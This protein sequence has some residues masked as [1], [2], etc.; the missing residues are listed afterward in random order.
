MPVSLSR[1]EST[2]DG[3]DV[4]VR[5][6]SENL[7]SKDLTALRLFVR[8]L[9]DG[10]SVMWYMWWSRESIDKKWLWQLQAAQAPK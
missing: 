2:T 8:Y 7:P 9:L 1:F 4:D 10:F 5:D 6:E 3:D